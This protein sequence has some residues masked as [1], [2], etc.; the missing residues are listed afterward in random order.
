MD[1]YEAEQEFAN[2]AFDILGKDALIEILKQ[3]DPIAVLSL[4][5]S[6]QNFARI[7]REQQTFKTLMRVHYPGFP[8]NQDAKAQYGAITA[9]EGVTY[10]IPILGG[11][12]D[13]EAQDEISR[14]MIG[15]FRRTQ[16]SPKSRAADEY[17]EELMAADVNGGRK[18]NGNKLEF[19]FGRIATPAPGA[20][21]PQ[22]LCTTQPIVIPATAN[23]IILGTRIRTGEKLWLLVRHNA[24]RIDARAFITQDDALD[25]IRFLRD[26]EHFASFET[27]IRRMSMIRRTNARA[28]LDMEAG[29]ERPAATDEQVNATLA[30][31]HLPPL[32]LTR[33][34]IRASVAKNGYIMIA[35][36][37]PDVGTGPAANREVRTNTQYQLFKVT[38]N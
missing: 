4:C 10:S 11:R 18:D 25:A 32:P 12:D 21:V 30:K 19:R 33:E 13:E 22:L 16:R 1:V 15:D 27:L 20:V 8:I 7:C 28:R 38:I 29:R 9:G 6:N 24:C 14:P 3:M 26:D 23:F 34:R 36:I 2:A 31:Y 35:P 37:G 5:Q 17:I